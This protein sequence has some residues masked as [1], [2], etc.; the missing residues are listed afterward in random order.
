MWKGWGVGALAT[1]HPLISLTSLMHFPS[2]TRA[3]K[4][5]DSDSALYRLRKEM[6]EFHL[7]VGS[8]IFGKHQHSTETDSAAC[9]AWAATDRVYSKL[10][11]NHM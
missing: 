6:E 8:G 10:Y 3:P 2:V 7:A 9:P 11:G 5:E 4:S 1:L